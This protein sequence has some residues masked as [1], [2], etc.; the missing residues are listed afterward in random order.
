M[1]NPKWD[2][3]WNFFIWVLSWQV[4]IRSVEPLGNPLNNFLYKH[5]LR[6]IWYRIFLFQ[7]IRYIIQMYKMT[8]IISFTKLQMDFTC[9]LFYHRIST[10]KDVS[11]SIYTRDIQKNFFPMCML[12]ELYNPPEK[13]YIST[14]GNENSFFGFDS[15][16]YDELSCRVLDNNTNNH[17]LSKTFIW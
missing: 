2:E 3:I 14:I 8:W 4:S 9:Q 5:L 1:K 10:I 12:K 7:F 15:H 11:P 6:T 16:F 13:F 17:F